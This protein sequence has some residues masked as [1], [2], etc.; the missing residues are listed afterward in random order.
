MLHEEDRHRGPENNVCLTEISKH[1]SGKRNDPCVPVSF[2]L[3][4][5]VR[6]FQKQHIYL[7]LRTQRVLVLW[8]TLNNHG[9]YKYLHSMIVLGQ[10]LLGWVT[11]GRPSPSPQWG[12]MEWL[13]GFTSST[14]WLMGSPSIWHFTGPPP[15]CLPVMP[16][17]W[18]ATR[19][20]DRLNSQSLWFPT[21]SPGVPSE[22]LFFSLFLL[23]FP[24]QNTPQ[25]NPR[26]RGASWHACW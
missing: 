23:A 13:T 20:R 6:E 22:S 8:R 17:T 5:Q 16:A 1:K 25:P 9:I 7:G 2:L 11:L 12:A 21:A 26:E 18:R 14:G 15:V 3:A 19:P 10:D 4:L 24:G